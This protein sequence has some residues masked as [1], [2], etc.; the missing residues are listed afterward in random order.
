MNPSLSPNSRMPVRALA[1]RHVARDE[2]RWMTF[3]CCRS[4]LRRAATNPTRKGGGKGFRSQTPSSMTRVAVAALPTKNTRKGTIR[5]NHPTPQKKR[6]RTCSC[7]PTHAKF[8][9]LL[10]QLSSK[11]FQRSE[12]ALYD[13]TNP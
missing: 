10:R 6:L 5:S 1:D 12:T 13:T 2:T 7:T 3:G 11:W 9:T 8:T 4:M